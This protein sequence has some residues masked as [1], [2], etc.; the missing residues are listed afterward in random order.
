M[1]S[2]SR[3]APS[4]EGAITASG[5]NSSNEEAPLHAVP[6]QHQPSEGRRGDGDREAA[7]GGEEEDSD[8]EGYEPFEFDSWPKLT[9][10]VYA[11]HDNDNNDANDEKNENDVDDNHDDDD[12][13]KPYDPFEFD[14]EPSSS[15]PPSLPTLPPRPKFTIYTGSEPSGAS[16]SSSS[17][18]TSSQ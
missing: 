11:G 8:G 2:T 1:L 5:S 17:T 6:L 13:D 16:S 10:K 14:S 7:E 9:S 3:S 12:N 18:T 4:S 15:P